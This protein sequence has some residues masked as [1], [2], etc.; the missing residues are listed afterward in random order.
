MKKDYRPITE[1]ELYRL[2]PYNKCYFNNNGE[3]VELTYM[4]MICDDTP[5]YCFLYLGYQYYLFNKEVVLIN[6][7]KEVQNG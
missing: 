7:L 5:K 6:I 4:G 1:Q 3:I 2:R